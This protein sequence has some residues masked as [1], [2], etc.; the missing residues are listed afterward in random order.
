MNEE[1]NVTEEITTTATEELLVVSEELLLE[2]NDA[3]EAVSPE[4]ALDNPN[5]ITDTGEITRALEA[6]VFASPKAITLKRIKGILGSFSYDTRPVVEIMDTL[7]EESKERGFQLVKVAG[8]YQYRSNPTQSDILQKLLEDKPVRL[9][10]SALEVLAIITYKQP[11]SRSEIDAVRGV[12]SGHLTRGLLDKNLIRTV[13]HAETPGRPLL[14][15]TTPYFLEVFT[16]NS[17]DDMPSLEDYDREL[18]AKKDNASN[19]DSEDDVSE[20]GPDLDAAA[21]DDASLFFDR[22]SPL[23]ANPDRGNFDEPSKDDEESP[24]FGLSER[25]AEEVQNH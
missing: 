15:G 14:Y 7:I 22:A 23:A 20:N 21:L 17:L 13:G 5:L 2:D 24:D 12:D 9:G 3:L 11:V 6:L 10:A 1:L 4:E 8:A 25:A 18:V 16:L 19:G